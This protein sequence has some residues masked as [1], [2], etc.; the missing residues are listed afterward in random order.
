[1]NVLQ[2]KKKKMWMCSVYH[3]FNNI[4]VE[5]LESQVEKFS[6]CLFKFYLYLCGEFLIFPGT[7]LRISSCTSSDFCPVLILWLY[8]NCRI[9]TELANVPDQQHVGV[10]SEG[11]NNDKSSYI[12][13]NLL[14]NDVSGDFNFPIR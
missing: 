7:I 5:W 4:S 10:A 1:M 6:V 14:A 9:S 13:N 12:Q 11:R 2:T 3:C 8:C